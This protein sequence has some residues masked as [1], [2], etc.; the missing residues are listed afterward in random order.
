MSVYE[1][2]KRAD[3]LLDRLHDWK[4]ETEDLGAC[5][6]SQDGLIGHCVVWYLDYNV[7]VDYQT[8]ERGVDVSEE[9]NRQGIVFLFAINRIAVRDGEQIENQLF[10]FIIGRIVF[11]MTRTDLVGFA[12][13]KEEAERRKQM[14]YPVR[15][16]MKI[17]KQ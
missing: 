13:I 3:R 14:S 16:M 9:V 15:T 11:L 17:K 5:Y 6:Y 7:F 8:D 1:A 2:R 4:W 12:D 10:P